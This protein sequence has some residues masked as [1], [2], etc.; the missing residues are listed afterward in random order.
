MIVSQSMLSDQHA[1]LG[2]IEGSIYGVTTGSQG[3]E[4][5]SVGMTAQWQ[6]HSVAGITSY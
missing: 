2:S 6:Q 4:A 1:Q 3:I 5:G